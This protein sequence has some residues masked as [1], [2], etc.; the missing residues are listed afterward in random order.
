MKAA[1]DIALS[2]KRNGKQMKAKFDLPHVTAFDNYYLDA[3]KE[4]SHVWSRALPAKSRQEGENASTSRLEPLLERKRRAQIPEDVCKQKLEQM[5]KSVIW[6]KVENQLDLNFQEMCQAAE[7]DNSETLFTESSLSKIPDSKAVEVSNE[8]KL[9]EL[10]KVVSTEGTSTPTST[11]SPVSS[12]SRDTS[13]VNPDQ[14]DSAAIL[15]FKKYSN[16]IRTRNR[17]K[18]ND[19]FKEE[20]VDY[21]ERPDDAPLTPNAVCG[22]LFLGLCL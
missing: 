8:D 13:P 11:E 7:A 10:L 2:S 4:V 19:P 1:T 6:S 15:R 20:S 14:D 12:I 16:I 22:S 9:E 3:L 21:A 18:I 5:I 17:G